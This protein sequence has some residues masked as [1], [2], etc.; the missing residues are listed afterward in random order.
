MFSILRSSSIKTCT[1]WKFG[2]V[3]IFCDSIWEQVLGE[4]VDLF[5]HARLEFRP[6]PQYAG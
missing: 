1:V 6:R 4:G 5:L 3:Y 2:S